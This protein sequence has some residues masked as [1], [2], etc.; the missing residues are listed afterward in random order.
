MADIFD[1]LAIDIRESID[2]EQLVYDLLNRDYP[3]DDWPDVK[4]YSEI[5]LDLNAA[6]EAGQVILYDVAQPVQ[7]DR[8]LWRFTV[9]F[10]VLAVGLNDP[11]G[12]ARNL[13]KTIMGWSR[14]GASNAGRVHKVNSIDAPERRND[15]KENQ[16]KNIKEYG[17]DAVLT[18][19]DLI[20]A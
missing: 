1:M 4:V 12:L 14:N 16:G 2:A 8:G 10:T 13:Y 3:N 18:A 7:V 15:A 11:S 20:K 17:F 6:A 19:R 5:D 9:S